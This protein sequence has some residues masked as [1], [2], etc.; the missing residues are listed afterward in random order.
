[1]NLLDRLFNRQPAP[2]RASSASRI[3]TLD[4]DELAVERYRYLLRTAPPDQLEQAHAEAFERLTPQQRAMVRA[5]LA[6]ADPMDAPASDDPRDLAR[7]ATRAELREPG[8]L[9]RTS[10]RQGAMPGMAGG[11][12]QTFAIAFMATSAA[13]LL[14]GGLYGPVGDSG[15]EGGGADAAASEDTPGD[16]AGGDAG[17]WDAGGWDAGGFG[18]MGGDFGDF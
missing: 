7:S 13:N 9:E 15:M 3:A 1:M 11:F 17:G 16:T 10:Q 4:P 8:T 6:A 5:D 2:S 14:F 18:D 12:L